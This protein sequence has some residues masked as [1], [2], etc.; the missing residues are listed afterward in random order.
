MINTNLPITVAP[1][2]IAVKPPY[3]KFGHSNTRVLVFKANEFFCGVNELRTTEYSFIPV[4][5]A[6][7]LTLAV[8]MLE[9]QFF[10]QMSSFV[11]EM[12]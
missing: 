1:A 3:A 9:F 2:K 12:S 7:Q 5:T 4:K 10:K 8:V 6:I 11:V